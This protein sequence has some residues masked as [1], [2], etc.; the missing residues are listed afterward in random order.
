MTARTLGRRE[1]LGIL[2]ATALAG[3][4][5]R[6][7]AQGASAPLTLGIQ[8]TSWGVVG[9]VAEGEQTFKKHGANVK[10]LLFDTGKTTRDAMIA[11]RV[12]IGVLGATPFIIGAAKGEMLGI[13]M[14][15][16]AG[17]TN[18]LVVAKGSGIKTV[19]DLKGRKVASQLGSATDYVF[20]NK[21]MP[22]FG[23]K[24][25]DVQI[26][27]TQ[28]QNQVSALVSKS[29]DA[30]AGVE[31]FPS[32]AEV[33]GIGTVLLDY[34]QFD[35]VPVI[36]AANRPVLEHKHEAAVAFFR[37]WLDAVG[38][39]KR[40]PA[41]AAKIVWNHFKSQGYEVKEAVIERMIAKLEIDPNYSPKLIAYLAEQSQILVKQHKIAAVPD[42]SKL[43]DTTVMKAA[44][45][46]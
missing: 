31:P 4:V 46:A 41:H 43:L 11:G 22:K 3:F 40:D 8:N 26:I 30:F 19:A 35:M 33:D 42:W 38:I 10:V 23:L 1:V 21:I 12:D 45:K 7:R 17:R 16:Y 34:S 15:M 13:G 6:A 18:A 39:M 32:V 24:K 28:F 14:S 37:G 9:M 27:N 36:L 29:V 25:G 44:E 20:E 5:P 2:G